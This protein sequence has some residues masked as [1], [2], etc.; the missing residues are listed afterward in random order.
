MK[1]LLHGIQLPSTVIS[2]SRA[3][4]HEKRLVHV[5]QCK[6]HMLVEA[7]QIP[8][9]NSSEAVDPTK[10]DNYPSTLLVEC[11]EQRVGSASFNVFCTASNGSFGSH[12]PQGR[13]SRD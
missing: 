12:L 8:G 4:E 6:I 11:L 5:E 2:V 9:A 7:M 10:V 13:R 1:P 3:G